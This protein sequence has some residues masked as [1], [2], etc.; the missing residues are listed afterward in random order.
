MTTKCFNLVCALAVSL[1][2]SH[3][4]SAQTSSDPEA[5]KKARA[6]FQAAEN[7]SINRLS[8]MDSAQRT[9]DQLKDQEQTWM[10]EIVYARGKTAFAK[11][12]LNHFL[13]IGDQA[14]IEKWRAQVD[15]WE[16]RHKAAVIE[17][18]KTGMQ[19][20]DAVQ[21]L[22]N[23]FKSTAAGIIIP[24]EA[25][26]VFVKEDDTLHK[27]YSVRQGGYI[28]MGNVGKI[29]VAGKTLAEAE[30]SIKEELSK[31]YIKNATVMVDRP[32]NAEFGNGTTIYLSGEFLKPGAWTVP[33]GLQPT[34]VTTI[35]R[36][37]GLKENAD[38]TKVR[39]LRIVSGQPLVE[40]INVK[41][42][43]SGAG[44]PT[45]VAL[46]P[47]DIV[48]VPPFANVVYVTGNV[49]KPGALKLLPDDELSAYTAIMRAG[50][51]SRFANRSKV[52][53]L[54]DMGNGAKQKIPVNIKDMQRGKGSDIILK[55]KDIIVV[56]EKFI[57]F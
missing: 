47:G 7:A 57:S 34:I 56:P 22:Q 16:T 26:E 19:I 4:A 40:E 3:A 25:I 23:S 30:Q 39:L 36:S 37:V 10:R 14:E 17:H 31:E 55:S 28:L 2:F 5:Y 27:V 20:H 41:A 29:Q 6:E 43:L 42:I 53:I 51:F 33:V 49:V 1:V 11:E 13:T 46:K 52:Y 8:G 24:G 21:S 44:L 45:D 35:L 54:R 48:H 18:E 12:K 9:I 15:N 50:G 38:L 32:E